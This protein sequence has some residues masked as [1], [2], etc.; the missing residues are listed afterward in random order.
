MANGKPLGNMKVILDLNSSAFSKGLEGA[1]K[2]VTYN[3]KAMKAQMQVMNA[4][5]DKLGALQSKYTGLD[6]VMQANKVQVDKLRDAYEKSFKE[7]GAAGDKT[8]KYA[9]DLNDAIGRQASFEA[10]MKKT[11]GQIARMKVETE[12]LTGKLKAQSEKWIASG[13]K[14]ESFGQKMSGMGNTLTMA[15]TAPIAAGFGMATKKAADFQTQ[16]G[17]IGPLLTNGGKMTAEYRSQLDQMSDSS[18]KWAKQYG[19]STTEINNGLAEVVRKGYDAN[20]T[21][22]VMPSI[23]DATKASGDGFNDVMNVTTEVISQFNLKGKDY[24]STVKNATRVTDAL[25]YVANATS[26]G[27]S[28]LGLA[29]GYVGPVA[30]SLGMDVEETASA[31]GLLSD[32]GIG[33]KEF[34]PVVWEQ[35]A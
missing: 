11:V 33:G 35:A 17:E 26:A 24:N 6:K 25:T 4:S 7:S 2:S 12:G 20:Q 9:N 14:I 10:Q 22:G 27:F 31:I 23:L 1:K 13:K 29:M 19:V 21:M 8:A 16:I 15:V 5:G 28:D 34:C 30:N 32:A 18:K 3:M